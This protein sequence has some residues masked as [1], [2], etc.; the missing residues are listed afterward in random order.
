MLRIYLG[1]ISADKSREV[2]L[3]LSI[4]AGQVDTLLPFEVS[5]RAR[6]ANGELMEAHREHAI[7]MSSREE[8]SAAPKNTALLNRLAEVELADRTAEALKLEKEGKRK[9]ASE[10]LAS[11]LRMNSPYI[12][13]DRS[14]YYRGLS[15]RLKEGMNELDRK[16]SHAESYK[17]KQRREET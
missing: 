6:G 2:Y 12:A 8:A 17:R 3:K 13:S 15:Q 14:D 5:V 11:T 10:M 16:R 7:S 9:E 4:P 1:S